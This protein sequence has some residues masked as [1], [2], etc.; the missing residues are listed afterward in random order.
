M[1]QGRDRST[2]GEEPV[3][4]TEK[5]MEGADELRSK[6]TI[7]QT[8][9][10]V[11]DTVSGENVKEPVSGATSDKEVRA[12]GQVSPGIREAQSAFQKALPGLL[13]SHFRQWVAYRGNE[14][15]GFA[16]SKADLYAECLRRGIARGQFILRRI[17]HDS[18]EDFPV[19]ASLDV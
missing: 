13:A 1:S 5:P 9:S 11:L 10:S 17:T 15:I 4:V 6:Q 18:L 2:T 8:R 12:F 7:A 19:E 14:Q 3:P 16:D